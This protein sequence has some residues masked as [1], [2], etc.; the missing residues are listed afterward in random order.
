MKFNEFN[1][2]SAQLKS[3]GRSI[4]ELVKETTGSPLNESY[5]AEE[6]WGFLFES[7]RNP[8]GFLFE[9]GELET[10]KAKTGFRSPRFAMAT[11]KLDKLAEQFLSNAK[12]KVL[13]KFMPPALDIL[14]K[15]TNKAAAMDGDKK[16]PQAILKMVD[17]QIKGVNKVQ[18]SAMVQLDKALDKFEANY[19]KG[20]A[21]IT[22]NPKLKEKNQEYLDT[23]WTLLTTQVRQKLY[24][25]M[26]EA[27][28]D[29]IEKTM[30][31]NKD[32]ADQIEKQTA[33]PHLN[34]A[35]DKMKKKA[36]EEK[37]A[38]A[39]KK[40]EEETLGSADET[41][42]G[43]E[44]FKIEVG[45]K[46][47]INGTSYEIREVKDGYIIAVNDKGEDK[48]ISKEKTPDDWAKFSKENLVTAKAPET[49]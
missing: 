21:R 7:E 4:N 10:S 3:E 27:R 29:L 8:T 32:L 44:E 22:N 9:G 46:Y 11:K 12:E 33:A 39:A 28:H 20:A 30:G 47:D 19:D 17:S 25:K 40:D 38:L 36:D 26:V 31:D 34:A 16:N 41:P 24:Q 45:Q 37:A 6:R 14:K 5:K 42:E 49:A 2:L 1:A 48:T 23:Y 15:I 13:N 35:I 43:S 18:D